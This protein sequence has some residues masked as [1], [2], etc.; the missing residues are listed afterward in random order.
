YFSTSM[1]NVGLGLNAPPPPT[2]CKCAGVAPGPTNKSVGRRIIRQSLGFGS[3]VR[4]KDYNMETH[5]TCC[6]CITYRSNI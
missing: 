3:T 4:S 2:S 1:A 5:T 6:S